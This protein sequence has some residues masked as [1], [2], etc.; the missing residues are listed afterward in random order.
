M[1]IIRKM[2]CQICGK[3]FTGVVNYSH[4]TCAQCGKVYSPCCP[5][6]A[7]KRCPNCGGELEDSAT[8]FNRLTGGNLVF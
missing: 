2:K 1:L 8:K 4:L 7:A 5:E 3:T 6:C